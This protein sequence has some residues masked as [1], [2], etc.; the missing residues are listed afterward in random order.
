MIFQHISSYR[1]EDELILFGRT[2]DGTCAVHTKLTPVLVCGSRPVQ[3]PSKND[4]YN[5]SVSVLSGY[6]ITKWRKR[7]F[8]ECKFNSALGFFVN[9]KKLEIKLKYLTTKLD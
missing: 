7:V 6:D 4:T 1:V 2:S 8:F 3:V 5:Y 9:R